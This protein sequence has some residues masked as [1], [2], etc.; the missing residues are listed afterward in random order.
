MDNL[1]EKIARCQ[2][3]FNLQINDPVEHR[4]RNF[5]FNAIQQ[6]GQGIIVK[7]WFCA[8]EIKQEVAALK[9]L[10]GNGIVRLIDADLEDNVL[11]L[12]KLFP[13]EM[14][15]TIK[16]DR[17]ATQIAAEVM[18]KIW[19][20]LSDEHE[21]PTTQQ[22]FERLNQAINLPDRFPA[23]MIDK[24]KGIAA[25]LHQDRQQQ[26]LLH[27]DLHHFNILSSMRQPWL[28]IDPKGVIGEREYEL[29][30]LLRNPVPNIVTTMNTQKVL[31]NRIAQLTEILNFDRQRIINWAF[32]QAVLAAVWALEDDSKDWELFLKCAEVLATIKA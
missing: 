23:K 13:G 11:L 17:K 24:A 4:T 25:D 10:A 6:D 3:K 18:Q 21:F 12:E 30:A 27:G 5:V 29:G 32:A 19:K 16:D 28:A 31:A 9:I 2:Q 1:K 26:V 20:P 7:F 22:W 15:S 14:L 8:E